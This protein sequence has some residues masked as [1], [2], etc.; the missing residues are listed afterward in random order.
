MGRARRRR[1]PTRCSPT[2]GSRSAATTSR[3]RAATGPH[4]LSEPEERILSDKSLTA[5]RRVGAAVLGAHLRDHRRPRRRDREPRGGPV[6]AAVARPRRAPSGRRRGHRRRSRRA[7]AP[8]RSCS[9]RCSSTSRSTTGCATTTAGSR[10]ATSTT[11]RATSRSRRSSTRCRRATTSR[12]AGTRSKAQLLGLDRIADYDR[13]A[14]VASADEEFGWNEARELVLDAYA[15]VLARARRP[16]RSAS[17]TS[18]G[19][20]RRSARGSGRA[21]SARTPCRASTRTCCST[22]RRAAATCSRSRTRWATASTPT[23]RAT[24]ASSTR[25]RRSRSPRPR[26]CS[27]RRSR[28]AGCSTRPTIPTQ[29]LALLAESLE[30]QIATVFRQV[31]MN[32]FEDRVHTVRRDEGEL[33][34]ER[35]NDAVGGHPGR[36]CSATRSRSPRATARGG[37]TSRTSWARPGYVYAYAYGQLLALSV[38]R[39]YEQQGATFVPR[40]LE[41]LR[42]RWVEVARGARRDR[43]PRPRR[44]GVLGRRARDR[45]RAAR[46]GR[47]RRARTGRRTGQRLVWHGRRGWRSASGGSGDHRVPRCPST[48]TSTCPHELEEH[49]AGH[50]GVS[51]GSATSRSSPRSCSRSPRCASRGAGTRP[52][53]GAGSRR[54]ATRRRARRAASRTAPRRRRQQARLQDLLNFNR[55]LEAEVAGNVAAGGPLRAAVPR[56][57]PARVRGVARAG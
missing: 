14:S 4:L 1:T 27:A 16:P 7:C 25:P 56:R 20:T 52:R 39:A 47:G 21:R 2:S 31:A 37:P 49:E 50:A 24:R 51:G 33:S 26:R 3:R 36:R 19:S 28:S 12:S 32:R 10:A 44:P 57:V 42:Q 40:Y 8:G 17:S 5:Q 53:S 6:A 34:V 54:G 29:R 43:R 30:G 22:G 41:L 38:Y 55:W 9:T 48:S 13:M 15:L 35:F 45:R 11:R 23:S 46:R 18:A